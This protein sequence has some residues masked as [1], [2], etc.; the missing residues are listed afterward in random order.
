MLNKCVPLYYVWHFYKKRFSVFQN[1]LDCSF[2]LMQPKY[3]SSVYI[4]ISLG[5]I[6]PA[7]IFQF[8]LFHDMWVK[9]C[10]KRYRGFC[11]YSGLVRPTDQ[12][13]TAISK[14][15]WWMLTYCSNHFA[16]CTYIESSFS[17]IPK[18]N[19]SVICQL[20][21]GK[22]GGRR[23]ESLLQF[24]REGACQATQGDLRKHQGGSGGQ[25]NVGK[26]WAW[27]FIF[28][29]VEKVRKGRVSRF[30]IG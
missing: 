28:V 20:Y 6:Y 29:S 16:I 23:G 11:F 7:Q 27:I 30:R 1:I 4:N 25:R 17:C 3:F 9:Y 8:W 22:T 13:M 15:I 18:T 24:P 5:S 14:V 10:F 2:F 12:E 19:N 21:L 26:K